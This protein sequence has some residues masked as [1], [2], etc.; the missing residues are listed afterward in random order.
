MCHT[1][2]PPRK[3]GGLIAGVGIAILLAA[4]A[5][6]AVLRFRAMDNA[7][8]ALVN[9]AWVKSD[10]VN[11][12][13]AATRTNGTATLELRMVNE[14]AEAKAA[15]FVDEVSDGSDDATKAAARWNLSAYTNAPKPQPEPQPD[16]AELAAQADRLQ[17]LNRSRLAL[18]P[19]TPN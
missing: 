17:R 19:A 6:L 7:T 3:R 10:A 15:G 5:T 11:S 4:V 1:P 8:D 9:D 18:L 16:A 13:D 14:S 2:A 12:L